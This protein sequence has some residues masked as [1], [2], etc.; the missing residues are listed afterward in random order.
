VV[1]VASEG[2]VARLVGEAH[3]IGH[4]AAV[5]EDGRKIG[6]LD[7][8]LLLHDRG[9]DR[10]RKKLLILLSDE[11]LDIFAVDLLCGGIVLLVFVQ[12]DCVRW[13]VVCGLV[14]A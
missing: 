6:L 3:E 12:D 8:E 11:D 13:A 9:D 10:L 2:D 1:K 7:V 4:E 14:S 5:E